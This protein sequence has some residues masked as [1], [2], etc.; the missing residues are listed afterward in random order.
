[1]G[2]A[3]ETNCAQF[4]SSVADD[5]TTSKT[6]I[7]KVQL[8]VAAPRSA[9]GKAVG[10][11]IF[12]ALVEVKLFGELP[13]NAFTT[14]LDPE[15]DA[16]VAETLSRAPNVF[17]TVDSEMKTIPRIAQVPAV[18]VSASDGSAVGVMVLL[19]SRSAVA[20]ADRNTGY[21]ESPSAL[22]IKLVAAGVPVPL[23]V[24]RVV[25]AN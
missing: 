20:T 8:E 19:R 15:D 6:S 17:N 24:G 1:V 13:E 4:T 2:V 10:R 25:E 11:L 23:L 7:S 5:A 16:P 3:L 18:S 9:V 21:L 14:K 22:V 12:G